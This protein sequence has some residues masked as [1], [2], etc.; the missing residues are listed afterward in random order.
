MQTSE[1]RS[2]ASH[3]IAKHSHKL[4]A[5]ARAV[6]GEEEIIRRSFANLRITLPI[7]TP[8]VRT[9]SQTKKKKKK[10]K[11]TSKKA[12]ESAGS[13]RENEEE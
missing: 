9:R 5:G 12:R 4:N 11:K 8:T 7:R 10:K 6:S 3:V 2:S 13:K 1:K